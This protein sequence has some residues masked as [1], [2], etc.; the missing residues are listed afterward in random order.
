MFYRL[1]EPPSVASCRAQKLTIH[2][3]DTNYCAYND[4]YNLQ[5]RAILEPALWSLLEDM[6]KGFLNLQHGTIDSNEDI[7]GWIPIVR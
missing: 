2:V 4:L 1:C 5:R 3:I 6:T 7:P